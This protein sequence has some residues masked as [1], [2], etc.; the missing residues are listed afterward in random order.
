M[1]TY[2]PRRNNACPNGLHPDYNPELDPAQNECT[3]PWLIIQSSS[4]VQH[5]TS[6]NRRE[7]ENFVREFDNGYFDPPGYPRRERSMFLSA[8]MQRL[9]DVAQAQPVAAALALL[10]GSGSGLPPFDAITWDGEDAC[11][12][13]RVAGGAWWHLF[14]GHAN[15]EAVTNHDAAKPGGAAPVLLWADHPDTWNEIDLPPAQGAPPHEMSGDVYAEDFASD[16]HAGDPEPPRMLPGAS[17][18]FVAAVPAA[19]IDKMVPGNPVYDDLLRQAQEAGTSGIVFLPDELTFPVSPDGFVS[20]TSVTIGDGGSPGFV[21]PPLPMRV[22]DMTDT[23]RRLHA[24]PELVEKI[25][26]LIA[27]PSTAVRR[28]RPLP[29]RVPQVPSEIAQASSNGTCPICLHL[30]IADEVDVH[31]SCL[32]NV[33]PMVGAD[34]CGRCGKHLTASEILGDMTDHNCAE[35]A[36]VWCGYHGEYYA[37][38]THTA[39]DCA[40]DR[41]NA[42]HDA[43]RALSDDV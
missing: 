43:V 9:L 39:E 14:L 42:D 5:L 4:P 23:E 40:F 33:P 22:E 21:L 18:P 37:A 36:D 10:A 29:R 17:M 13:L 2:E 24:N 6:W 3:C 11:L 7:L 41:A 26:A 12:S 25:E 38:G 16:P 31:P 35:P 1:K 27:D 20:G 28:E 32:P 30:L 34:V 15:V 8:S 19:D